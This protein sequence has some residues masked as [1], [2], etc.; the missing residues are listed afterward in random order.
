MPELKSIAPLSAA[1]R[2]WFLDIWGVLHNGVRPF[3]GAVT[4]CQKFREQ[5]G[6]VILVSN[7]PRPRD[8][9]KRQ[10]DQIGVAPS[11]YDA[12]VTSGDV[13]RGLIT[14][15][16]GRSVFHLGP[17]RDSAIYDGTGALPV[18]SGHADA[19]VCTGLFD[20]DRETPA[21]YT[22]RLASFK[23]RGLPMICVNPDQ[24]VERGGRIVYCA[25]ALAA[26]Y[27]KLGGTVSYA[28]KP[29]APIYAEAE[30]VAA[31]L[32]GSPVAKAN[33][34]AIGDGVKTDILGAARAGIRSV[35]IASAV[36]AHANE[37]LAHAAARLF[38]DPA[39]APIGV[40]NGLRW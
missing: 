34:L 2:V 4:A 10:L 9:V 27:E 31:S 40:M 20:D 26:A 17:E 14:A 22:D 29:Y 15:Y 39:L 32:A 1:T 12:I 16:S 6:I 35:Y 19:I 36:H 33:I 18:A 21:D 13:S 28:G 8:G 24:T 38:P 30:R 23:A 37:T 11:A 7:S 25:G 3:A 5:G